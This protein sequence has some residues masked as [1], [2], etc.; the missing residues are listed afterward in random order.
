MA[1]HLKH[2]LRPFVRVIILERL[3]CNQ[4]VVGVR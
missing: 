1:G 3:I 2:P 4:E